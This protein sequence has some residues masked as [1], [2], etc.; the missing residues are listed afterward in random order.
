MLLLCIKI[1]SEVT[2][3]STKKRDCR[4]NTSSVQGNVQ[5][6]VIDMHGGTIVKKADTAAASMEDL[7][8]DDRKELERELEE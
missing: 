1:G 8:E 4:R 6:G 7:A 5:L 3:E 2:Q